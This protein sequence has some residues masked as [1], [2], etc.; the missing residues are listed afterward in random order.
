MFQCS[1]SENPVS[2]NKQINPQFVSRKRVVFPDFNPVSKQF[3]ERVYDSIQMYYKNRIKEDFNGMF[4]IAK[5]GEILFERYQGVANSLQ[6]EDIDKHTPLHVASMSKVITAYVIMQ[7]VQ[8]KKIRLDQD[9]RGIL[10]EIMYE[11]I[12]IR[13]LLNHRSG[14]PYYGY[15]SEKIWPSTKDMTNASILRVLNQQKMALYFPPNSQFSYC[16]TNYALLALIAERIDKKKF[17]ALVKERIFDPLGMNRSFIFDASVDRD[18]ISQS[19]DGKR[20]LHPFTNL[21]G[22]YGDKNLYTTARDLLKLDM[23]SYS[24]DFLPDSLKQEM[25]RGYSYERKGKSNYGLGFRIREEQGKSKFL[26]H[27][28]WWHGNTGCYATLRD[29]TICMIVISNHYTK[30]VYSINRLSMLFGNYPF[31][32]LIDGKENFINPQVGMRH[33]GKYTTLKRRKK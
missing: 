21:D 8:E 13:M 14:I 24:N 11:G 1:C 30:K 27:T 29:D 28:G 33:V 25:F 7:L 9:I 26:F 16:N 12:T 15:F 3:K 19:Y 20:R 5:N 10:P 32:P 22:V 17:P 23:A 31:A 4:L 6:K 2:R 18:T